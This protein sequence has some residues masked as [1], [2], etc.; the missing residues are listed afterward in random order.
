VAAAGARSGAR[1]CGRR[2][3]RVGSGASAPTPR[4]S[5]A[6]PPVHDEGGVVHARLQLQLIVA[7]NGGRPLRCLC[8]CTLAVAGGARGAGAGAGA[9]ACALAAAAGA[10]TP[11]RGGLGVRLVLRRRGRGRKAGQREQQQQGGAAGAGRRRRGAARAAGSAA[12]AA[13]PRRP[14]AAVALTGHML[15]LP[16]PRVPLGLADRQHRAEGRGKVRDREIPAEI[17]AVCRI[18]TIYGLQGAATRPRATRHPRP[19]PPRRRRPR[20]CRRAGCWAAGCSRVAARPPPC[21]LGH[22]FLHVAGPLRQRAPTDASFR[23]PGA[24]RREG[25]LDGA[26]QT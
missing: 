7:P 19:R 22:L 26:G 25:A 20:R 16:L 21:H 2:S 6:R 10:S 5:C 9:P 14:A 23:R 18:C 12:A 3:A 8:L 11:R 1:D 24:G 17:G 13:S 15:L 4:P